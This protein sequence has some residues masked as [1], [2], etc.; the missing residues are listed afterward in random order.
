[1]RSAGAQKRISAFKTLSYN[2][3]K[4]WSLNYAMIRYDMF[5]GFSD[6]VGLSAL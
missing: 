1:M 6:I 4:A 3:Y 5:V 2:A